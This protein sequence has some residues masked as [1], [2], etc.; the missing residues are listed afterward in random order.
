MLKLFLALL[1]ALPAAPPEVFEPARFGEGQVWEYHVRPGDEGSLLRIQQV[2]TSPE[3]RDPVY[4]ISVIG[5]RLNGQAGTMIAHLPVSEQTL[6][7]SVTR[8]SPS[9]AAFPSAAEGI[10]TWRANRG[11]V[12]DIPLARIIEAIDASIRAQTAPAPVT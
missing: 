1:L 4:H 5:V 8:E 3:G 2:E 9:D 6:N 12:F 10:A 11:G 7:A